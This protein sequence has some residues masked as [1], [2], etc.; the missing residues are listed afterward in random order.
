MP[1]PAKQITVLIQQDKT[2]LQFDLYNQ[3]LLTAGTAAFISEAERHLSLL[4]T[5]KLGY[6]QTRLYACAQIFV[7]GTSFISQG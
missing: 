6:S 5:Y 3:L 4:S 2:G 1:R 7:E